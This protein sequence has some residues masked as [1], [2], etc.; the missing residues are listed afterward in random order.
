MIIIYIENER[1]YDKTM[2]EEQMNKWNKR[3]VNI[4]KSYNKIIS[5]GFITILIYFCLSFIWIVYS[6]WIVESLTKDFETLHRIQSFKG[7]A[8]V[9]I[10]SLFMVVIMNYYNSLIYNLNEAFKESEDKRKELSID[11]YKNELYRLM[12]SYLTGEYDSTQQIVKDIFRYLFNR[13]DACDQGS[14]FSIGE[15]YINYLDCVGYNLDSLNELNLPVDKIELYTF[16]INKNKSPEKSLEAKLGIQEYEKYSA[17][18]PAIHESIYIGF[19]DEENIKFGISLDISEKKYQETRATYS[20][21]VVKELKDIQFLMTSMF[22]IKNMVGMK[23]IIQSDIVSS[24]IA[25]LEYHDEYAKG[26]SE[27]V[28]SIAEG[29]G[30]ELLLSQDDLDELHW[31]SLIHDLGKIVIPNSILNKPGELSDEEYELVK[32]HSINGETFLKRSK[33]LKVIA[34]YVRHHHE[35]YDGKGYPDGLIGEE[36]PLLARIITLAD[37]YHAM[38]SERP[39]R[40]ALTHQSALQELIDNDGKQF[41]PIV[42]EA[43]LKMKDKL[44]L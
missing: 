8:F 13:V 1:A 34:K 44:D 5:R 33:S 25:T 7:I 6:D 15:E 31:A 19:I 42:L 39:Y 24:F 32:E 20:D 37:A 14:A 23:S 11:S 17:S 18:N 35:R 2:K 27:E 29:I 43:F 4:E 9:V 10:T 16:S 41:C 28:A 36:I 30:K 21:E 38:T 12:T 3:N 26:H 40:K 22:R